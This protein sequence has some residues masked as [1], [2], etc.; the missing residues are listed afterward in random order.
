VK[1][2]SFIFNPKKGKI[3]KITVPIF[4]NAAMGPKRDRDINRNRKYLFSFNN[5]E[6]WFL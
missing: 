2:I 4:A 3:N 6:K 1:F 5:I